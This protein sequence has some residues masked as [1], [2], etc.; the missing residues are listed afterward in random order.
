MDCFLNEM[1][2]YQCL[3]TVTS[4]SNSSQSVYYHHC[5]KHLT[6]SIVLRSG[7][8]LYDLLNMMV[9]CSKGGN[10]ILPSQL[11]LFPFLDSSH[12]ACT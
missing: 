7:A 10:G 12:M 5:I 3:V 8:I 6:F 1:E 9:E 2:A 11:H 4:S